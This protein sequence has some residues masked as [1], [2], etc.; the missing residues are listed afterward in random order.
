MRKL[1]NI[2]FL[3][4]FVV[5]FSSCF[6][7]EE[8]RTLPPTNGDLE[9]GVAEMTDD[10]RYQVYYDQVTNTAAKSVLTTS[11]DLGFACSDTTWHIVLNNAKAMLAGNSG[12]KNFGEVTTTAGIKFTFDS[13]NGDTDSLAIS[14]WIDLTGEEPQATGYVYV[15][16]RGADENFISIGYKKVIFKT[17]GNDSYQIRFANPDGSNEQVATIKKDAAKNYVCFSFDNGIVDV[18]P[19]KTSW[20]LLF[21]SYQ[22]V[23]YTNQGEAVP[24]L[25]R[26]ALL[27]PYLTA[28]GMDTTLVFSEISLADTVKF[29]LTTR[30]DVI[31][32]EWKYYDFDDGI[33]MVEPDRNYIVR[34]Q[35]SYYYKLRFISYY[36]NLNQKGYPAFEFMRM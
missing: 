7:E 14:N 6:Q 27:N 1:K 9:V 3:L 2:V 17:S 18:E 15:I 19:P 26:G 33:Y 34:G 25:V 36:N 12:K 20:T 21:T 11:W 32:H 28:A 16:D 10:Y 8:L 29:N 31:G 23:L 24:Y 5:I 30:R 35:D 22:A 13:T 4:G